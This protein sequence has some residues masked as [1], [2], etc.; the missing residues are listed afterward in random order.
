MNFK[1]LTDKCREEF[2]QKK[3][4]SFKRINWF[5]EKAFIEGKSMKQDILEAR[6]RFLR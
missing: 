3:T 2:N 4:M 1:E 6:S 5:M